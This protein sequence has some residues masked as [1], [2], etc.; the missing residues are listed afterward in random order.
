MYKRIILQFV[1]LSYVAAFG[2]I[3]A[4]NIREA[5]PV[6]NMGRASFVST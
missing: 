5:L 3:C 1:R 2:E 6:G 4:E